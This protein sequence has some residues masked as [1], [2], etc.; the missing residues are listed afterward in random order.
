MEIV[1]Q[2]LVLL[3]MFCLGY[4]LGKFIH[5]SEIVIYKEKEIILYQVGDYVAYTHCSRTRFGYITDVKKVG[6][7]SLYSIDDYPNY[8]RGDILW[9]EINPHFKARD[10]VEYLKQQIENMRQQDKRRE[11][12]N[13]RLLVESKDLIVKNREYE[14]LI[15]D[16]KFKLDVYQEIIK[17]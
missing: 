13:S 14:S 6:N 12:H 8:T 4:K 17:K 1:L 11:G 2:C 5:E 9:R 3:V 15:R 7:V 10:Q 16:L